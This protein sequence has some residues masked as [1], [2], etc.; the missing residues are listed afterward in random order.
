MELLAIR[1]SEPKGARLVAGY[2]AQAGIQMIESIPAQQDLS[3][4]LLHRH[5]CL[6]DSGLRRNDKLQVR[7]H[8][9]LSHR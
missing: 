9:L 4:C 2:P 5:F 3:V 8:T 7:K 1:L 6:L